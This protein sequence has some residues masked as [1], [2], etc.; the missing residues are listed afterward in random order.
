[1]VATLFLVE[2]EASMRQDCRQFL[3][4]NGYKVFGATDGEDA[5]ARRGSGLD[6]LIG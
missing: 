2:D 6:P 3:A 4:G 5:Y 1:V